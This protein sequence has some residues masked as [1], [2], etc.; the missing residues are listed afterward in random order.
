MVKPLQPPKRKN[1]LKRTRLPVALPNMRSR[2]SHLLTRA[3][4]QGEFGLP[5]CKDCGQLHYPPRDACPA[6]LSEKIIVSPCSNLGLV[7][8]VTQVD[9]SN[10][11]YFRERTPW[12][13]GT[14]TMDVGPALI[15]HVH[16]DCHAG[17]RVKL[18][19]Q[20]DRGGNAA[21][22]AL[23]IAGSENMQDDAQ[24]REMTL[25]PKHRRVL[26]TDGRSALGQAMAK[27]MSDAG[28][29]IIFVGLAEPWKPFEGSEKLNSIR[30]V[31]MMPLDTSDTD[32]VTEL[33]DE[34]GGRVDIIINTREHIRP[35]GLLDRK[36][37]TVAREEL[38]SGYLSLLRLAQAFGPTL[39]FRGAD[40]GNNAC[41]WVN[42][43]SIYAQM[44]WP[45]YG[46]YSASQA[47]MLGAS[48]SLRGE[49]R[50]GGIQVL[51]IFTGPTDDEWFQP[52]PPPKVAHSQIAN[53]VVNALRNGLEDVWVGDV[54]QDFKARLAANPK[55]LEREIGQ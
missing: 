20:L 23:P 54:A 22:F 24:F 3:A 44:S 19:W 33:A 41:A 25:D 37:V 30:G 32:S 36:G 46:A 31:E 55:A 28:A 13:V 45:A 42:V 8:A 50:Q 49:L 26:I 6:C 47:A 43:F 11:V 52:L 16:G 18:T 40:G 12:R 53:A 38:D 7:A 51:H 27:A 10:N 1:P 39:K 4:A 14:I 48:M 34:I 21:A 29:A 15:A 5:A 35:G 9:I 17:Q 2:Q